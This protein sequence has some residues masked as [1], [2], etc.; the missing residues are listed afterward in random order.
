MAGV[1]GLMTNMFTRRCTRSLVLASPSQSDRKRSTRLCECSGPVPSMPCGSSIVRPDDCSHLSSP[2]H[3][4]LSMMICAPLL[5]SPNWAS[6]MARLRGE[7][8][9]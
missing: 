5:K 4:K 1:V 7:L 8:V 2:L 6:Q 9:E 3:T